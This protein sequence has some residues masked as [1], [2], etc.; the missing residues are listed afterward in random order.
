MSSLVPYNHNTLRFMQGLNTAG[1]TYKVMLLNAS[2]SFNATH[3]TLT[4]VSNASAYEVYGN[5][6]PQGGVTLANVTLATAATNGAMLDAD[7][8]SV[9]V[10]PAAL[11]PYKAY[12]IYNATDANSPPLAYVQLASEVTVPAGINAGITF[13][14]NGIF[15]VTVA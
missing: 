1:D 6:W 3:T 14:D 2:A 10:T 9:A 8:V 11:G 13:G 7:D 15:K 5:G 12:V 4:Q